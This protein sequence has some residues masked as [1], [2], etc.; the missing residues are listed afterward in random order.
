[1]KFLPA[2][3]FAC[4]AGAL[5]E[6]GSNK[7]LHIFVNFLTAARAGFTIY[8]QACELPAFA[9]IRVHS[10]AFLPAR[11]TLTKLP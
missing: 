5:R 4:P 9:Q 1:L 6:G 3:Q 11:E 10:R 7:I 2:A 8:P